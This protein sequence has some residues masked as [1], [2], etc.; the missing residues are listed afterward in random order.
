MQFNRV[1]KEGLSEK[2]MFE[3]NL[4]EAKEQSLQISGERAIG[5]ERGVPEA[6]FRSE[7]EQPEGQHG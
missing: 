5:A 2:V 7:Q 4:E 6:A 3:Q 1:V